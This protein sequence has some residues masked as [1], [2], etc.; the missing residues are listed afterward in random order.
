MAGKGKVFE[1]YQVIS[2]KY[3]VK[4]MD[5]FNRFQYWCQPIFIV[6]TWIDVD[7]DNGMADG[8]SEDLTKIH[9]RGL[10]TGR[11]FTR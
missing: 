7:I 5:I 1:E 6:R 2:I 9:Q 4:K 11:I 3:Q 8:K 10:C